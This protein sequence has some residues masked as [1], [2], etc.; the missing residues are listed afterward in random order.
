MLAKVRPS[1]S[2]EVNC[3]VELAFEI[4]VR[5]PTEYAPAPSYCKD[6]FGVP[7]STDELQEPEV[8]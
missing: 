4:W 8:R 5:L 6:T 7:A 1:A 2:N 3:V